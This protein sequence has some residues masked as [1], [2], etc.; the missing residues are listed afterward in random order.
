M[1]KAEKK[2]GSQSEAVGTSRQ[3]KLLRMASNLVSDGTSSEESSSDCEAMDDKYITNRQG[4]SFI[5]DG[6]SDSDDDDDGGGLTLKKRNVVVEDFDSDDEVS[7][8]HSAKHTHFVASVKEPLLFCLLEGKT[9][10]CFMKSE[11][12]R[13]LKKSWF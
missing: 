6:Q 1:K 13:V 9:Y 8:T 5:G 3:D 4:V 12:P 10:H 11:F 7:W 2:L